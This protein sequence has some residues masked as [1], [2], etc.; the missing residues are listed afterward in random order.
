[1]AGTPLA[2]PGVTHEVGCTRPAPVSSGP[3]LGEVD[4]RLVEAL[5]PLVARYGALG[6]KHTVDLLTERP[7]SSGE[8]ATGEA[9]CRICHHAPEH[10]T[11]SGCDRC[12]CREYR[13]APVVTP[14]A[15]D[16]A[17]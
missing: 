11:L 15:E 1:M 5:R 16:G 4:P 8:A 13:P 6:V 2:G 10:H 7:V 3:T 14:S 12:R 9:G 17:P